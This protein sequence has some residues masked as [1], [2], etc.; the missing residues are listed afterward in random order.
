MDRT[1]RTDEKKIRGLGE[2]L[3]V[4]VVNPGMMPRDTTAVVRKKGKGL[5]RER[6]RKEFGMISMTAFRDPG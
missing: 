4:G 6:E 3:R 2:G 1:N 5:R